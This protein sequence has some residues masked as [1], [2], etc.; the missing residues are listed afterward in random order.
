MAGL[1]KGQ[2]VKRGQGGRNRTGGEHVRDAK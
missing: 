2:S 1:E